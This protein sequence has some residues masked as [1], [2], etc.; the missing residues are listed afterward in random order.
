MSYDFSWSMLCIGFWNKICSL[1]VLE[2]IS[3]NKHSQSIKFYDTWKKEKK[4]NRKKL[5]K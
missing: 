1:Q 3:W 5:S 4:M 2:F